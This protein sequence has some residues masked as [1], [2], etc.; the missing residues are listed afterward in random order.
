MCIMSLQKIWS[1]KY[2]S[3]EQTQE[4]LCYQSGGS[5]SVI[6]CHVKS[7]VKPLLRFILY[8][9]IPSYCEGGVCIWQKCS[10]VC[11]LS[12]ACAYFCFVKG[13]ALLGCTLPDNIQVLKYL[14]YRPT[15]LTT[16]F[17]L[18]RVTWHG[19]VLGIVQ[20][21]AQHMQAKP[22]KWLNVRES[23]CNEETADWSRHC[24]FGSN[25]PLHGWKVPHFDLGL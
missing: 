8:L 25:L 13:H 5:I 3:V 12:Y 17:P 23:A 10:C 15:Y 2:L 1:T 24:K 18:F 21:S 16:A 14:C 6:F 11:H 22:Y 19:R 20:C 4:Q 7:V 9:V